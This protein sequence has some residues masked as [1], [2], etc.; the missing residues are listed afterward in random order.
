MKYLFTIL[1]TILSFS[2]IYSQRSLGL[3]IDTLPV[4]TEDF[5]A[6]FIHKGDTVGLI[7]TIDQVQKIDSDLE[8]LSWLEKKGFTCDSTI[9]IYIKLVDDFEKQVTI[10]KT[11]VSELNKDI[12]DK[13]SQ[14]KILKEKGEKY[15]EDLKLANTEILKLNKVVDNS[16]QRI[17]NLKIQRNL[18]IG[19]GVLVA[20]AATL[21]TY[22]LLIK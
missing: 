20:T 14:I 1:L 11:T 18:S 16:N 4:K 8:L 15:E 7:F 19:G 17:T 6:W 12:T 21:I 22:F 3:D 2:S 5:P 9:A 13:N 10:L